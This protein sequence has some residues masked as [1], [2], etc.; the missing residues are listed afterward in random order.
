[1][2]GDIRKTRGSNFIRN[3][4]METKKFIDEML[5]FASQKHFSDIHISSNSRTRIRDI[6]GEI[7]EIDAFPDIITENDVMEIIKVLI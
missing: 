6:N 7:T 4:K 5:N 3:Y 2:E 1:M